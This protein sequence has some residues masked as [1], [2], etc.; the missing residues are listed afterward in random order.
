M[1]RNHPIPGNLPHY[2]LP[3]KT[4]SAAGSGKKNKVFSSPF[5]RWRWWRPSRQFSARRWLPS[6]APAAGGRLEAPLDWC[7]VAAVSPRPDALK[8]KHSESSVPRG[9][10][11]HSGALSGSKDWNRRSISD[12][13]GKHTFCTQCVYTRGDDDVGGRVKETVVRAKEEGGSPAPN[14]HFIRR[15]KS[16]LNS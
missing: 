16:G 7:E 10:Q 4:T 12:G 15:H 11:L 13:L 1:N 5:S 14:G 8:T 9:S 6:R 3:R 2:F